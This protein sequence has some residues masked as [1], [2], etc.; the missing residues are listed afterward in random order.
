MERLGGKHICGDYNSLG[1]L[2]DGTYPAINFTVLQKTGERVELWL[3]SENVY[4][5]FHA[6]K[7]LSRTKTTKGGRVAYLRM[8]KKVRKE[9]LNCQLQGLVKQA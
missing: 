1:E 8:I 4:T 3:E 5:L 2:W 6:N 7:E 9:M